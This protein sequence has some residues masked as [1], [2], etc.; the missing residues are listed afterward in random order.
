MKNKYFLKNPAENIFCNVNINYTVWFTK[1]L[2]KYRIGDI[3]IKITTI[4][5]DFYEISVRP[6]IFCQ[7][8]LWVWQLY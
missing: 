4:K 5:L 3:Y 1:S 6:N 2:N 7:L 8:G